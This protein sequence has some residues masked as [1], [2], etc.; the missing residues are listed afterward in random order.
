MENF[1]TSKS[2]I[3]S[4]LYNNYD[5]DKHIIDQVD[6]TIDEENIKSF[7]VNEHDDNIK[8]EE[9]II[10][11]DILNLNLTNRKNRYYMSSF[12]LSRI[13]GTR[14]TQLSNGFPT[15]IKNPHLTN[16]L[17]IAKE[18]LKQSQ[19]PLII[20]RYN[21]DNSYEDWLVNELIY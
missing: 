4:D 13:I 20:R 18:E 6:D 17:D 3:Q 12:E 9:L 2:D 10:V 14:A 15:K 16:P 19:I 11:D 5:N 8:K 21:T 1:S 7:N